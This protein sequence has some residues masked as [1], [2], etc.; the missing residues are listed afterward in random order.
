MKILG[1]ILISV[2]V[3][4]GVSNYILNNRQGIF[5]AA[6]LAIWGI[7]LILGRHINYKFN[8]FTLSGVLLLSIGTYGL[9]F[10]KTTKAHDY[11]VSTNISAIVVCFLLG[12]IALFKGH[13]LH[14]EALHSDVMLCPKC[15]GHL[16]GVDTPGFFAFE[17]RLHRVIWFLFFC[18]VTILGAGLLMVFYSKNGALIIYFILSAAWGYKLYSRL[19][20][21]I[22]YECQICK[23][24]FKGSNLTEFAYE[25]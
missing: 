13:Q 1:I 23:S 20:N 18:V 5:G 24:K 22:I 25:S 21:E 7:L 8:I 12:L 4:S 2:G 9:S 15:G 17:K 19:M 6:L 14:K 11:F 10:E 16:L 3:L